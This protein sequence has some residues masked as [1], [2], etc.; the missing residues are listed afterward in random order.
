VTPPPLSRH[1][2]TPNRRPQLVAVTWARTVPVELLA[3]SLSV[4]DHARLGGLR[5]GGDR[6][7]SA[8]ARVLLRAAVGAWTGA[9]ADA[10]VIRTACA[11]CG[12]TDHGKPF[13]APTPAISAM[14]H[15]SVAHADDVVVVAV[16]AAGP[17]GVDVEPVDAAQFDGFDAV[18]LSQVERAAQGLREPG[19]RVRTWVRKE[20]VLKATGLGLTIDP[21]SVVVSAAHEP[22]RVVGPPAGDDAAHWQ[23][24]DVELTPGL[25]C[26]VAVRTG[27]SGSLEVQVA[28]LDVGS[29]ISGG[30]S[31]RNSHA[32]N[33]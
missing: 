31:D 27:P 21:R 11:L 14:P 22:P 19:A 5:R 23:L 9:P 12:A 17:V 10:V 3:R 24:R 26:A 30:S 20:A 28:E 29:L 2:A 25:A 33:R 32:S 8:S 7:R 18:A 13:V 1:D 4:D 16:T 6:D 15:V